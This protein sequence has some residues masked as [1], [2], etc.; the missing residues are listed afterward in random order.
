MRER[1]TPRGSKNWI[2]AVIALGLLF[3]ASLSAL[4]NESKPDAKKGEGTYPVGAAPLVRVYNLGYCEL[5]HNPFNDNSIWI[6]TGTL[7]N[8]SPS[9]LH[10]VQVT[11]GI[12]EG[13]GTLVE[14][15]SETIADLLPNAQ[16]GFDVEFF[17]YPGNSYR[18]TEVRIEP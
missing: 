9:T 16:Q 14:N 2:P 12:R 18:V 10:S 15:D 11:V 1:T 17:Q 3:L 7:R 8:I 4:A 13:N 5:T 6:V